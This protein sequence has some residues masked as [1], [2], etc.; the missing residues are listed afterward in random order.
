MKRKTALLIVLA[1]VFISF[2][3]CAESLTDEINNVTGEIVVKYD[4]QISPLALVGGKTMNLTVKIFKDSELTGA[5]M[6]VALYNEL[7]LGD[8]KLADGVETAAGDGYQ[9]TFTNSI[10]LP[11]D[12]SDCYMKIFLWDGEQKPL[13]NQLKLINI[14]YPIIYTYNAANRIATIEYRGKT[15]TYTYDDNG[16]IVTIST[17]ETMT[18]TFQNNFGLQNMLR[19]MSNNSQLGGYG[20]NSNTGDNGNTGELNS[21]PAPNLNDYMLISVETVTD[22]DG[23]SR[24]VSTYDLSLAEDDDLNY[25]ELTDIELEE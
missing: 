15:A 25:N 7:S 5:Q 11:D 12:V 17:A 6:Y 18:M 8:V 4:N 20:I 21:Q 16:N 22:A 14:L 23:N 3:V 24:T 13:S 10:A 9:Y 19:A 1:A 2:S